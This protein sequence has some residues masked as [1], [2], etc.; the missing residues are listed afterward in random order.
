MS[1]S[2]RCA[3]AAKATTQSIASPFKQLAPAVTAPHKTPVVAPAEPHTSHSLGKK[4]I[5]GSMSISSGIGVATQVRYAHTDSIAVPD[6]SFYRRSSVKSPVA[7][8]K[9]SA[10]AR[11]LRNYV[12]T[13]G[14]TVGAAYGAK[15]LV[16]TLIGSMSAS[17]DVLAL[18]KVEVD[19]SAIT[20]G[21]SVVVK[22]RG[23]PLFIRHRT[24][25]EIAAEE[26]VDP[27]S[28]RH[29][30]SDQERVKDPK[31]LVLIGICTHLGCVPIANKG[32]YNGYYCPCHG[33]HYDV[34][35]R[36]RKGPAPL[37]LEIPPYEFA[38]NELMVVG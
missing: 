11:K 24:G 36:I 30:E 4:R 37:N 25:A 14:L 33:S 29:A 12:V 5:L 23:K 38:S 16:H 31:W 34:S 26:A 15:G 17:A 20:E 10:E 1:W 18:A 3:S 7:K 27:A 6:F 2:S 19:L 21:K 35:G 28:L 22:W 8:N 9:D 13:G 32:A